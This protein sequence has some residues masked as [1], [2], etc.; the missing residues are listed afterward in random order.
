[1]LSHYGAKN[2]AK[3]TAILLGLCAQRISLVTNS[4]DPNQ[5]SEVERLAFSALEEIDPRLL[6]N[7]DALFKALCSEH[8]ET[9][10]GVLKTVETLRNDKQ[11]D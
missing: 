4:Q 9:I 5:K 7:R 1:M 6:S 10:V 2:V 11:Q 8:P 3:H